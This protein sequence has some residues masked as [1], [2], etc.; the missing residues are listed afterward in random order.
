[1]E[2]RFREVPLLPAD[3]SLRQ[4]ALTIMEDLETKHDVG[5]AGFKFMAGGRLRWVQV[6]VQVSP[7]WRSP[8]HA[9]V[10]TRLPRRTQ[11]A[12]PPP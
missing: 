10:H 5:A 9:K 3:P 12:H 7:F 4:E 11:P 1:M 2:D 8:N 6:H